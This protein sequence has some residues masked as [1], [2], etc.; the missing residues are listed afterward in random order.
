[1]S[2]ERTY[3]GDNMY[4]MFWVGFIAGFLANAAIVIVTAKAL[5]ITGCH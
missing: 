5:G 4:T 2:D 1:M 3:S